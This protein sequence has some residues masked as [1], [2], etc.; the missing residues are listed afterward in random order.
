M[1]M[2]RNYTQEQDKQLIELHNQGL[3]YKD[4]GKIMNIPSTSLTYHAHKLGIEKPKKKEFTKEEELLICDLYDKHKNLKEVGRIINCAPIS[5]RRVLDRNGKDHIVNNIDA[6]RKYT[7]DDCYFDK[8]DSEDKA[9]FLGLLLTDGCLSRPYYKNNNKKYNQ[10]KLCLQDTDKEIL[11]KFR[12]C[13]NNTRPL[14]F[15]DLKHIKE[16]YHNSYEF[17]IISEHMHN[18]LCEIGITPN[19]SLTTCY[20]DCIPEEFDRPFIR[21]LIDGDGCIYK[22]KTFRVSLMGTENLLK[23]VRNKILYYTD[24]PS[25]IETPNGKYNS[26]TKDLRINGK[27][28]TKFF[29]DWLYDNSTIYIKRKYEIYK[30]KYCDNFTYYGSPLSD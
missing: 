8:I 19:K 26:A 12:D 14:R 25:V 30:D 15:I 22:K 18:R 20:P 29:L 10:I 27:L 16:S 9:Y 28:N 21:G 17:M 13:T 1:S 7:V 3:S 24:V 11:E 5:V 23:T 6:L 4:I 2:N